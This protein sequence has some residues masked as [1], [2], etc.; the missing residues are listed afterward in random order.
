MEECHNTLGEL[1]MNDLLRPENTS[2]SKIELLA[3]IAS[4]MVEMHRHGD[5]NGDLRLGAV[6]HG[7]LKPDNIMVRCLAVSTCMRIVC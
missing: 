3:G 6:I 7:D 4:G 1:I 2:T 5:A